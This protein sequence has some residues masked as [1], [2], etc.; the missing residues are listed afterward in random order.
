MNRWAWAEVNLN[1]IEKNL[2]AIKK[3]IKAPKLLVVVKANS[4]GHG[5]VEVSKK[6]VEIGADYLA[7]ATFD[8]AMQLRSAG[9]KTPILILGLVPPE[10][11]RDLV[12]Y[13]ITQTVCDLPL[14]VEISKQAVKL[15]KR[16][17]VHLK[18]ETGM[19]RIGADV[20]GIG[21]LASAINSLPGVIL[22]GVFSHFANADSADKSFTVKQLQKFQAAIDEIEKYKVKIPIKHIAE[23]A[24]IL[25]IPEAHFDMV[26][27]GIITYG[28]MPSS[29]VHRTIDLQ[30]AFRLCAKIAWIKQISAGTSI[31]YGRDFVALRDSTIAT[32]PIGYADG[33]LRAYARD[34]FVE[35]NGFKAPIAGRVCMDQTM[36]DVTDVPDVKVG[37]EVT[38]FGS[39]TL[40]IDDIARRVGTINYE[41][42]CLITERVP[43]LY[44]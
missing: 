40:T 7:V 42:P 26:R 16:A 29:E 37:D 2:R 28:L 21:I 39:D 4:Y 18:I 5:A 17:K 20:Q 23:S 19:G 25:E 24:A 30:T 34:G 3:H 6:A 12:A 44:I 9:F 31:G 8:E 11:A 15:G 32:L 43:R 33:F 27:S 35:V 41:I 14:A 38:L 10:C 36:I 22:E 13:D 1:A